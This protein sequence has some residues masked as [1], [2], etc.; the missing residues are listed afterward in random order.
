M[1]MRSDKSA[2]RVMLTVQRWLKHSSTAVS[3]ILSQYWR[4]LSRRDPVFKE[5]LFVGNNCLKIQKKHLSIAKFVDRGRTITTHHL[6]SLSS[7]PI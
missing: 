4:A 6:S 5:T 3:Q 2:G 1:S 7:P